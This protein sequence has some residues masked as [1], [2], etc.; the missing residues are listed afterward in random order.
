M[1][2][3]QPTNRLRPGTPISAAW[4]QWGPYLSERQWGTVREDYSADGAA[5]DYFPHDHARSRAYRWGEDGIL[6]ISD[7]QGLLCFAPAFWNG[8]DP[9]LKERLFGLNGTEGNHA[10]DVKEHYRFLDN[11]PDHSYMKALYRYPQPAFPYGELVIENQRRGRDER[12]YEL[13]DTGVFA[14]GRFWDIEIEYAKAG[15][16]DIAI[17]ITSTNR[18]PDTATLHLV[19]QFWF[20]NTWSW[21][22]QARRPQIVV[23]DREDAIPEVLARHHRLGDFFLAGPIGAELLFTENE[24]NTERLWG[25]PNEQPYVKDGIGR[26]IVE[27]VQ[28]ATNPSLHGTKVALRLSTTLSSGA[29]T[30][31]TLRISRSSIADPFGDVDQLF[32][33]RIA[34]ADRFYAAIGGD[35]LTDDES[36]VRRQAFAGLLWSKQWYG[37]DVARWLD[38]D[39][40][41]PKPPAERLHGRNRQWRHLNNADVI[42]MPDTWEYPWYAAWDLAFHCIPL[43]LLDPQLAKD[44]LL[45]FTREWYMHPNGQLPAYEWA[46]G[47]VNPP[48]HA[49]AAWRVYKIE[50]RLAGQGDSTFLKR[51][52]HKL[53]I[54]FT[55]WVNRKDSEGKNVFQG[56]FLGLDNIGVFDRSQELPTG[57]YLEQSDATAWMGMYC[58]NMMAIALELARTDIS[59]EDSATKFFEHFMYIAGAMNG[60]ALD[61]DPRD[62]LWDE[63]DG[64]FYDVLHLPDGH[65]ERLKIRSLVGLIPLL[66]VETIEP[67]LMERLPD[68]AA[69]LKWFLS[70]RKDLAAHVPSWDAPGEGERRL[71]A[72]VHGERLTRVLTRMLD[73]NEFLSDHGVRSLSKAHLTEPFTF[74]TNDT[75]SE[76]RYEPA[77]SQGGL[78]GG[79]SNWRGPVWFPIN[80]LLIE[81]LERFHHY[82]GDRFSIEHPTGSG[83]NRTLHEVKN[84]LA[85]RL[86]RL[87]L[88]DSS[89][90]RPYVGASVLAGDPLWADQLLFHEYFNGDTGEGL[91]ASHQTGWTALVAKLL[92]SRSRSGERAA[93]R[94]EISLS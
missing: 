93:Q 74:P 94:A 49:W 26:A 16:D 47:D 66:A 32:A 31:A 25:V 57:G 65:A 18:G 53:L 24:S 62:D 27:G 33:T 68:F 3:P 5:W 89:G 36:A 42:L 82:Y 8:V 78:F 11:T 20:R 23:H 10:E 39:P 48:V 90:R 13:A 64:F 84:D 54:N 76:V 85:D 52:F 46:F 15:P 75:I 70:Y 59:Y 67:E 73:S 50:K 14:G 41:A 40:A 56:G 43:A 34:E 71:L 6:G 1:T 30:V 37:F 86:I 9:I 81:A 83:V 35:L 7:D 17:R 44:Q 69:R 22:K 61:V 38:G 29:T 63:E 79:N 55:W 80:F 87:F 21:R 2:E 45:L 12:E 92:D 88:P 77:E 72:L 58:L 60:N 28:G 91:G 4:R 51:I 19:P